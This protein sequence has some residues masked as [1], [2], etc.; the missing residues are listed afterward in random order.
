MS[1][2]R[3]VR[4]LLDVRTPTPEPQ[5]GTT[6]IISA[7]DPETEPSAGA[8]GVGAAGAGAP[9]DATRA[10]RLQLSPA[11]H[12]WT[13]P[14]RGNS[15][16]DAQPE[17]IVETSVDRVVWRSVHAGFGLRERP[18][19]SS[20]G[21]ARALRPREHRL[22]RTAPTPRASS[23][24][25][26]ASFRLEPD[27]KIAVKL[28]F[29]ERAALRLLNWLAHENALILRSR[30][31]LPLLYDVGRH[32]PSGAG[33]D[34]VRLPE[35]ARPGPRGLRRTR[36]RP[37]RR[38]DRPR[39]A[40]PRARRPGL[41]HRVELRDGVSLPAEVVLLT[42]SDGSAPGQYHCVVRYRVGDRWFRDDPSAQAGDAPAGAELRLMRLQRATPLR[43]LRR[44]PAPRP[45]RLRCV[46]ATVRTTS[47][48]SAAAPAAPARG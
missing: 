23:S 1:L 13:H 4:P 17:V 26:T 11:R 2:F 3:H 15:R 31:D 32:L 22:P 35:P 9:S 18:E 6:W 20:T 28:A 42:D 21:G 43:T 24:S 45:Q 44:E 39:L 14:P 38:A 16:P 46:V 47:C 37:R 7:T 41:R 29:D 19:L 40:G 12:R 33:R 30:P 34:L 48:A 36:C 8:P 5:T 27:M 10:P 25:P